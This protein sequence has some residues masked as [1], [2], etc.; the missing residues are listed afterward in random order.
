MRMTGN[1]MDSEESRLL[2]CVGCGAFYPARTTDGRLVPSGG[3]QGG[4]CKTCGSDEF[5]Q[6]TLAPSD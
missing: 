6:V 4:R 1:G 3:S 5:E 2:Q